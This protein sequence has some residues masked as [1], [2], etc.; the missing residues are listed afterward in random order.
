MLERQ[1]ANGPAP[2]IA[3]VS[4]KGLSGEDTGEFHASLDLGL[5]LTR[6]PTR[7]TRRRRRDLS[8]PALWPR[9]S[10]RCRDE[11]RADAAVLHAVFAGDRDWLVPGNVCGL[12]RRGPVFGPRW[13]CRSTLCGVGCRGLSWCMH[14][15]GW[16]GP[17]P[18]GCRVLVVVP[19]A[20]VGSGMRHGIT[21]VPGLWCAGPGR[22]GR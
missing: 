22:A 11:A 6:T 1:P 20:R 9:D 12:A 7:G 4:D 3:I 2:G 10:R 18:C 16:P 14:R 13:L 15:A 5:A 17:A 8:G 19:A 21:A